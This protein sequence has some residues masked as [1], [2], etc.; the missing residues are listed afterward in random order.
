VHHLPQKA[1]KNSYEFQITTNIDV[2]LPGLC[3][4][5]VSA[6]IEEKR[7]IPPDRARVADVRVG[8]DDDRITFV[9]WN[10]ARTARDTFR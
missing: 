6:Q 4:V 9:V 10:S 5:S 2:E 3:A 7:P 8:F 1:L